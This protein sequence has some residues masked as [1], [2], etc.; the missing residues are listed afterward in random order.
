MLRD[1]HPFPLRELS[2]KERSPYLFGI[3]DS[4]NV[5]QCIYYIFGIFIIKGC[6]FEGIYVLTSALDNGSFVQETKNRRKFCHAYIQDLVKEASD[7]N[8][9][10]EAFQKLWPQMFIE[11]VRDA[12][13][14]ISNKDSYTKLCLQRIIDQKP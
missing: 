12:V 1:L 13:L 8:M 9:K 5:S 6:C 4:Q 11:L 7:I 10:N 3:S 14:E 2:P